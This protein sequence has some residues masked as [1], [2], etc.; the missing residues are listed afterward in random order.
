VNL[1][2]EERFVNRSI[3]KTVRANPNL[4]TEKVSKL[5][6]KRALK[7]LT[8]AG[9]AIT[10]ETSEG[11]I[12]WARQ[13]VDSIRFW[14][15]VS[16]PSSTPPDLAARLEKAF[17]TIAPEELARHDAEKLLA[18]KERADRA[19]LLRRSAHPGSGFDRSAVLDGDA[20]EDVADADFLVEK[21]MPEASVIG[22]VGATG[23]FKS[24]LGIDL[25]G[26]L[27]IGA[28]VLGELKT[29]GPRRVVFVAGEG[30][31]GLRMRRRAFI[32]DRKLDQ[33]D[34][35]L[36][37]SNFLVYPAPLNL[38]S[39]ED[40]EGLRR[41]VDEVG[42]DLVIF[43]TLSALTQGFEENSAG[44]MADA[45]RAAR[46]VVSG[47]ESASALVIHHPGKSA[48]VEG[49]GSGAWKA[50][51][52][53]VLATQKD[54]DLVSLTI[55]KAKDSSPDF[56]RILRK[57]VVEIPSSTSSNGVRHEA[58]TSVALVVVPLGVA[59]MFGTGKPVSANGKRAN[60]IYSL[61]PPHNAPEGISRLEIV[62]SRLSS[63]DE[64]RVTTTNAFNLLISDGRI[65][66][67]GKPDVGSPERFRKIY[68]PNSSDA[69]LLVEE[70]E[71]P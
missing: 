56:R 53:V 58:T 49:R 62:E 61:V 41:Y 67:T 3:E 63:H 6:A 18:D 64:K 13:V 44:D 45:L 17:P 8:K 30:P 21:L 19:A 37:A 43:D 34:R 46:Y 50:N 27:A 31:R 15:A 60:D 29:V 55:E 38:L 57:V 39:S 68:V 28:A 7:E 20:L 23:T 59:G 71:T 25:G 52:D 14:E 47:R 65:E 69:V 24:A 10:S 16:V 1:A 36:L 11:L 32:V 51:L 9:E 42:A 4:E 66:S 26:S 2:D 5:A 70:V 35:D 12:E 22:L 33:G 54:G 48:G 40:M